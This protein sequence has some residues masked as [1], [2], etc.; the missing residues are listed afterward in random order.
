MGNQKNLLKLKKISSHVSPE[1]NN[2]PER[3]KK[4]SFSRNFS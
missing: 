1:G 2:K 4:K 3:T